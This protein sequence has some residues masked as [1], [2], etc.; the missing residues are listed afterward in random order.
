MRAR[1]NAMMM[2]AGLS[3]LLITCGPSSMPAYPEWTGT[4]NSYSPEGWEA[5]ANHTRYHVLSPMLIVVKP[6]KKAASAISLIAEFTNIKYRDDV[7]VEIPLTVQ[8]DG[9]FAARFTSFKSLQ[10][11][12]GFFSVQ[13]FLKL[14]PD[15]LVKL[16][17]PLELLVQA[18]GM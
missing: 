14:T 10:V 3:N 5:G 18:G 15:K 7:T 2:M 6:P 1:F 16:S 4:R 9:S 12:T 17:P 11:G 8:E 13:L